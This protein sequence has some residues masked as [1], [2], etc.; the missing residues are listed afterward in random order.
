M[1]LSN[2]DIEQGLVNGA[3]GII[4]EIVW[5]L[6][7]DRLDVRYRHSIFTYR[8]WQRWS[9]FDQ[10]KINTVSCTPKLWN[11]R[12]NAAPNNIML[13]MHSS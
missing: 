9:S 7:R 5:P 1:L 10:A 8:L 12:A 2:I 4:I 11:D 3:M 13:G 6:F